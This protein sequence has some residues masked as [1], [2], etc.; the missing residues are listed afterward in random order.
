MSNESLWVFV[1]LKGVCH[2]ATVPETAI[3]ATSRVRKGSEGRLQT[4]L[5]E[6]CPVNLYNPMTSSVDK[7]DR[8][9]VRLIGVNGRQRKH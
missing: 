7:G 8:N 4:T 2:Q 5:E 9:Y 6:L 3:E 1:H